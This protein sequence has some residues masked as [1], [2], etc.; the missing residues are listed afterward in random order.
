MI[1]LVSREIPVLTFKTIPFSTFHSQK[2]NQ[3]ID[4]SCEI[5]IYKWIWKILFREKIH[6]ISKET[7]LYFCSLLI[8]LS[9]EHYSMSRGA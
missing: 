1:N 5:E 2:L 8:T 9:S 4:I 3:I 6:F 7:F